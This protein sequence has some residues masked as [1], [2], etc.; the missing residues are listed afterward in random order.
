MKRWFFW[1]LA[2]ILLAMGLGL[3][4]IVVPPNWLGC[5]VLY[6]FCGTLVL[7]TLALSAPIRFRWAVKGVAAV[8]LLTYLAYAVTEI[9]AWR[10]GKPFDF[11]GRAQCNLLNALQ[12]LVVF[13]VPS[14]YLLL[15]G[16][17]RSSVDVILGVE[18]EQAAD[19]ENKDAGE[20]DAEL[21]DHHIPR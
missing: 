19:A 14:V 7:A 3:P 2:P 13:G 9:I 20:Q 6:V 10:H 4:F 11:G 1:I 17:S 8:V 5:L 15:T 18:E 21:D 16:R 12:G